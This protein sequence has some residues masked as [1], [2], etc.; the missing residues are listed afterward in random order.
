MGAHRRNG[1]FLFCLK[2]SGTQRRGTEADLKTVRAKLK[3]EQSALLSL[4]A[5]LEAANLLVPVELEQLLP[6]KKKAA[7]AC[8][9]RAMRLRRPA[10]AH[11]CRGRSRTVSWPGL[12]K[13]VAGRVV[14]SK[15]SL[16]MRRPG[17]PEA[18]GAALSAARRRRR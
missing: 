12:F 16:G 1:K 5:E 3:A 9:D 18:A 17:A 6:V 2:L 15:E 4:E 14:Y 8:Q 10:W 13:S 7:T 11:P